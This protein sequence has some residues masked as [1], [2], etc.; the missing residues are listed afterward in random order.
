MNALVYEAPLRIPGFSITGGI[1]ARMSRAGYMKLELQGH[2][3]YK[4]GA[5]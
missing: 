3:R 2:L 1:H 5:S 4:A